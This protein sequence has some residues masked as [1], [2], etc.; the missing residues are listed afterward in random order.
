[1]VLFL[2]ILNLLKQQKLG[3][4]SEIFPALWWSGSLC[5][6]LCTPQAWGCGAVAVAVV[7]G[8]GLVCPVCVKTV[9]W[10]PG[11]AAFTFDLMKLFC[12]PCRVTRLYPW[13][14]GAQLDKQVST[15]FVFKM[16]GLL[17]SGINKEFVLLYGISAENW[18]SV[19]SFAKLWTS[20]YPDGEGWAGAGGLCQLRGGAPLWLGKR[21]RWAALSARAPSSPGR[22]VS[23]LWSGRGRRDPPLP[24]LRLLTAHPSPPPPPH[25]AALGAAARQGARRFPAAPPSLPHAQGRAAGT[26]PP[27]PPV[28]SAGGR[29]RPLS[30]LPAQAAGAARRRPCAPRQ[31]RREAGGGGRAVPGGKWALPPPPQPAAPEALRGSGVS[32]PRFSLHPSLPPVPASQ[33]LS[34]WSRL[35]RSPEGEVS[36]CEARPARGPPL[37]AERDVALGGGCPRRS[38]RRLRCGSV[39]GAGSSAADAW[40]C[41]SHSASNGVS[42]S[43][44][45]CQLPRSCQPG[46][47][48][49][50]RV[51]PSASSWRLSPSRSREAGACDSFRNVPFSIARRSVWWYFCPKP[52]GTVGPGFTP[53]LTAVIQQMLCDFVMFIHEFPPAFSLKQ[54]HLGS[55]WFLNTCSSGQWAGGPGAAR[56]GGGWFGLVS[57][58]QEGRCEWESGNVWL[59]L[60]LIHHQLQKDQNQHAHLFKTGG[61]SSAL[62]FSRDVCSET[63][64]GFRLSSVLYL[65]VQETWISRSRSH[66]A[67]G[68]WCVSSAVIILEGASETGSRAL[69]CLASMPG[70][71]G[72]P[73]S[74]VCPGVRTKLIIEAREGFGI[75]YSGSPRS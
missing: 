2:N 72:F 3:P 39:R 65:L 70:I 40:S 20:W 12:S 8:A 61:G 59:L 10:T 36:P 31:R 29:C 25:G 26:A 44:R 18:D 68:Q 23:F 1:M 46:E 57:I 30:P 67:S 17:I 33:P 37:S 9:L 41:R 15:V 63:S 34:R 35:R 54:L 27:A 56:H 73:L 43:G 47:K 52:S 7:P 38:V 51:T 13:R 71:A 21:P 55:G 28:S 22:S 11:Q 66:L 49:A 50:P 24:L 16:R 42:S 14:N 62:T 4:T 6:D 48:A 64:V 32:P 19:S 45:T 53:Q 75:S 69:R 74:P 5:R 58:L 60:G